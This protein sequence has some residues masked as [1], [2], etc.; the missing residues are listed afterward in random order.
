MFELY[1]CCGN[2]LD[3]LTLLLFLT[4]D[5]EKFVSRRVNVNRKNEKQAN[6]YGSL[7]TY[8]TYKV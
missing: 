8:Y 2:H 5:F 1:D 3:A 7:T 6:V 4:S